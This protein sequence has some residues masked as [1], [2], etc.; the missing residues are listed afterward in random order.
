M[1]ASQCSTGEQKALLI[2]IVLATARLQAE[3][4]G[5]TPLLLLD[6]MSA[7]LDEDRRRALFDMICQM[8]AQA[9]ITGTDANI[10]KDV[11]ER[12]QHFQVRNASIERC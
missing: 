1:E 7:H 12:A 10:Y 5:H 6:E 8:G 11:G 3:E 2:G 4:R 9:W